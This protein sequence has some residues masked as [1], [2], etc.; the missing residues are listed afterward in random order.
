MAKSEKAPKKAKAPTVKV[1]RLAALTGDSVAAIAMLRELAASG[2]VAAGASL[3]ELLAFSGEWRELI[4][5]AAALVAQ[6]KAVYAANVFDDMVRLLGRAAVETGD[7]QGVKAAIE[8]AWAIARAAS[9][10][11]N[12]PRRH[13]TILAAL[14]AYCDRAGQAPHE[15]IRLWDVP[16]RDRTAGEKAAAYAD[17]VA[18]MLTLRPKLRGDPV[19][20]A[21]HEFALAVAND[22][23]EEIVRLYPLKEEARSFAD[24]CAYARQIA[25]DDP[26]RA[27]AAIA[28]KLA[29]WYP[30]DVAQVAPVDPLLVDRAIAPLVDAERCALVLRTPRAGK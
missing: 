7:F 2:D 26:V 11:P 21:K 22:Q 23:L 27:W 24:A 9:L 14:A 30:V 13:E 29:E 4:V 1:A 28:A 8:P 19:G 17:A 3:A 15:L 6:P 16:S 20:I 5:H 18:N 25:S 10:P 12:V